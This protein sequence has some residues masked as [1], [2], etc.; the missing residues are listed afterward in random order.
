MV[1]PMRA[2]CP[3]FLLTQ[4]HPVIKRGMLGWLIAMGSMACAWAT[5]PLYLCPGNLFTNDV[6]PAQARSRACVLAQAGRL[7]QARDQELTSDPA[8]PIQPNASAETSQAAPGSAR[9]TQAPVSLNDGLTQR[10]RDS[11]ARE[12]ILAELARTQAQLQSLSAQTR[13]GPETDSAL[14]RLRGDEEALRREL[15]RRPG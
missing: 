2:P 5:P 11:H 10:Q 3:H 1:I 8:A 9:K 13:S 14:Q 15:A 4:L 7:S 12:I 6:D